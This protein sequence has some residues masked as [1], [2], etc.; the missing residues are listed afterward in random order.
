MTL[1]EVQEAAMSAL[2]L[3]LGSRKDVRRASRLD[4]G[5]T[6]AEVEFMDGARFSLRLLA[7]RPG[8]PGA[9]PPRT[10]TAGPRGR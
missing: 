1:A 6:A 9:P 5:G 2:I 7:Q 3:G 10:G 8:I 4:T